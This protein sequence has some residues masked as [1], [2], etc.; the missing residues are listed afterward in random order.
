MGLTGTHVFTIGALLG[1]AVHVGALELRPREHV[2]R[3]RV[4]RVGVTG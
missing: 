2:A 3:I 1:E 4:H